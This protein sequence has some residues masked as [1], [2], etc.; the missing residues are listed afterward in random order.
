MKKLSLVLGS[1]ICISFGS[2]WAQGEKAVEVSV[3]KVFIP[4]E[5][6]DDNDSVELVV[7]GYLPNAC[8]K[9]DNQK[10]EKDEKTKTIRIY[11]YAIKETEGVCAD[12]TKLPEQLKQ[13]VPF[14]LDV[15]VGQLPMGTY[16]I[17]YNSNGDQLSQRG[18]KVS[19]ALAP[20]VDS[21]PYANVTGV[22]M[23]EFVSAGTSAS[24]TIRGTLS[25]SCVHLDEVKVVQQ[26]DVFV[27][28]PTIRV[29]NKICLQ[30]LRP[31]EKTVV[32]GA[33]PIGRY[34]THIR[35]MNGKAVNHV[36]SVVPTEQTK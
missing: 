9:V 3:S 16:N 4:A 6:Y 7:D 24:A 11:Q 17:L 10:I 14:T 29:E 1:L 31:F 5:G 8:Y 32:L 36:F 2:A 19:K 22:Y 34:L 21:L 12:E 28:L 25:S 13:I 15:R 26:G 23:S 33:A 30:F 20:T 18:F 35:S 27:V